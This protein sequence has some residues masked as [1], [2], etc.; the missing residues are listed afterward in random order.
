MDF[1]AVDKR[2]MTSLAKKA[3]AGALSPDE[4]AQLENYRR[5]GYLLDL[6][7]SKARRSLR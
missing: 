3:Q 1:D 5:A 4:E 6:I 7:H 2:R